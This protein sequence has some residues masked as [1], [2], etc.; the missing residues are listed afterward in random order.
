[1][2]PFLLLLL[3]S[4][5]GL[6]VHASSEARGVSCKAFPGTSDW[7]SP[8]TWASL[9]A[10]TEGRLLQPVPPGAVCHPTQPNY[11]ATLCYWVQYYWG[12][13]YFHDQD[14]VSAEWNNWT[15]DSCLPDPNAPCSSEGYPVYVL[16]ATDAKH[17][18]AGIDF[19][20][21]R[22]PPHFVSHTEINSKQGNTTSD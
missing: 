13:E 6:G 19:G 11:N 1:M 18:K 8:E 14:P 4:F 17:V 5:L 16:N 3:L 7:P 10:T 2:M 9:N 21:F 12:N 15:N 20:E 22:N